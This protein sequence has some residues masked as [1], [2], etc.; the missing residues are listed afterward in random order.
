MLFTAAK[1]LL[2]VE[3]TD[4]LLPAV[5]SRMERVNPLT[6]KCFYRVIAEAWGICAFSI[7]LL[8]FRDIFPLYE[9][10]TTE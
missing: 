3:I 6:Y 9:N 5:S 7:D 10:L 2:I 8:F 4:R 1:T